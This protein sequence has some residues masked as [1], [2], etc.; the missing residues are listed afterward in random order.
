MHIDTLEQVDVGDSTQWIRIRGRYASNPVL[1]LIQQGPGLPMLNEA[2]RFERDLAL[3]EA[4]TVV[5][6]DQ[7]GCGRSLRSHTP[8]AEIT[9]DRMVDDTVAL[10]EH[11]RDRFGSPTF[12]AGFSLG[13]TIGAG[14]AAWRPDL[15]AALVAVGTDIDGPHA[16]QAAYDY[17]VGT[18]RI[19][20][21]R[22]ATRQLETIGPP[23]HLT[24]KQFST[25]LR[26]ASNFGGVSRD[27]TYGSL[28]RELLVSLL[29]SSDYS[30]GDIIRTLRGIGT[31]RAALLRDVA[32]LDLVESVKTIDV[33]V[34]LVQ[35]RRDRVA[36]G[37]DAQRYLTA[38]EAPSKQ[39]VW[40][41][42]SAHTPHLDEPDKF[43]DLL[44]QVR[45]GRRYAA[46]STAA[47]APAP[48]PVG[49]PPSV[50]LVD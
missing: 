4:F 44:L 36:P 32:S 16:Q 19:R 5:Y 11:L 47:R 48:I 37:E 21:A 14:A 2:A 45:A 26:W 1:L 29:T 42:F 8:A 23:P 34:T 9:I 49:R 10:L 50:E 40:F 22:R 46:V 33:P 15:V 6:W 24:V 41:E 13:A 3:E 27:E 7:R 12:V 17:V 39:L 43:R 25:R 30:P 20:R 35:G 31:T 18:A 28:V 38:L